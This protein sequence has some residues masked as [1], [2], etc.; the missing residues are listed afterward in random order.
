[1]AS[2]APELSW[3][4]RVVFSKQNDGPRTISSSTEQF[5]QRQRRRKL[6]RVILAVLCVLFF[7]STG[8]IALAVA[9]VLD[10][11]EVQGASLSRDLILHAAILSLLYVVL[12]I[13]AALRR[14]TTTQMGQSYTCGDGLHA[15]ALVVARLSIAT[16]ICALVA[17]A[18]MISKASP[19]H[20]L[21]SKS[22]I[23]NLLICIGAL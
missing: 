1:M 23:L 17:T 14:N 10:P 21:A 9:L 4:G 6:P 2:L 11:A 22:P 8:G 5:N 7:S 12:H 3:Q 13:R 15:S 16:W 19:L 20:G 18:A